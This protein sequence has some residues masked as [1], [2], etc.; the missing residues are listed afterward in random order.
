MTPSQNT[1]YSLKPLKTLKKPTKNPLKTL[2]KSSKNLQ[3]IIKNPTNN[4]N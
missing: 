2:K 3:K 1:L 4:K